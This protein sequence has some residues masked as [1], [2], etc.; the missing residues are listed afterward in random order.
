MG[1]FSPKSQRPFMSRFL[2]RWIQIRIDAA[3]NARS[4]DVQTASRSTRI[5]FAILEAHLDKSE[6]IPTHAA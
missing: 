6:G 5:R 4:L 3:L 2:T 1:P